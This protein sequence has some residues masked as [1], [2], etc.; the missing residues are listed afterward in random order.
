MRASRGLR[1]G[2]QKLTKGQGSQSAD[3]RT[4]PQMGFPLEHERIAAGDRQSQT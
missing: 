3:E 1:T 4:D 2:A